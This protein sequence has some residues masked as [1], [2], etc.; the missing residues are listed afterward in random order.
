MS[1][2]RRACTNR[3]YT[4]S[5]VVYVSISAIVAHVIHWVHRGQQPPPTDN[6][7]V[8][9]VCPV[10]THVVST[11]YFCSCYALIDVCYLL[12]DSVIESAIYKSVLTFFNSFQQSAI[13]LF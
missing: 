7:G 9:L 13:R 6:A 12:V 5:H 3:V 4:R 2:N 10:C 8:F 11:C 1:R